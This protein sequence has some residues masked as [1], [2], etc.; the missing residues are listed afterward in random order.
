MEAAAA[1]G[2]DE[3]LRMGESSSSSCSSSSLAG[4]MALAHDVAWR[5]GGCR[6]SASCCWLGGRPSSPCCVPTV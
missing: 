3:V 5:L 1:H 6:C 2:T 4:W